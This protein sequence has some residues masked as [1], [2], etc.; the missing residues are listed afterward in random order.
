MRHRRVLSVALVA[1]TAAGV[2]ALA[3]LVSSRAV[4]PPQI[5]LN[6]AVPAFTVARL[7]PGDSV[8]RCLRAR[9]EGE[10]AIAMVDALAVTGALAPYLRVTAERG[11]GLGDTGPSCAGFTPAG[12]Y[13]YGTRAGGVAPARLVPEADPAWEAHAAKSLRITVALPPETPLAASAKSAT[14]AIAFAGQGLEEPAGGA[15]TPDL[16]GGI[17][18]GT[19]G[20]FTADGGFLTNGQIKKRLRIGRARLLKNGNV[21]VRMFLPVGGAIRAKV[22]LPNGVYYAHTLLP[23]E[24]GPTVR[25]L[26][27]RR[28]VGKDAALEARRT[29]RRLATTVT[30]R[31]RWARGPRAF[32]QPEQKLTIVRPRR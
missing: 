26:L 15:T 11:T 1:A 28:D 27:V 23:E 32:V 19:T 2:P 8:T 4:A 22:I 20:G 16:P 6:T 25:V 29:G 21:V 7:L 24:W 3:S 13:A 9:N 12:G 10:A 18:P 5:S 30:T 14:V 17:A 31:Y